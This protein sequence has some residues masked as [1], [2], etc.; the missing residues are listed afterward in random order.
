MPAKPTKPYVTKD[1]GTRTTTSSG[2]KREIK[3][4]QPRFD[5]LI[6][7]NVP[8]DRQLLTRAAALV[9]RGAEKYADRDWEKAKTQVELDV[10]KESAFRH[11]MQ[12]FTGETDEDHAAAVLFNLLAVETV[13][14]KIKAGEVQ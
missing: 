2:M 8:Y 3:A 7:A 12:W 5:L 10:F 4:E 11:F 6:P 1:T 14:F 9:A 13:D